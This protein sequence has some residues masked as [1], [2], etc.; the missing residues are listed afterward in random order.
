M[1]K[2]NEQ[3]KDKPIVKVG[4][5]VEPFRPKNIVKQLLAKK[6]IKGNNTKKKQINDSKKNINTFKKIA[7]LS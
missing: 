2:Y 4:I 1:N 7:C 5:I 3:T 6:P